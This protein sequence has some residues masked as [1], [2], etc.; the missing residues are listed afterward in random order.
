M[1]TEEVKIDYGMALL[2]PPKKL[3]I[4]GKKPAA[5]PAKEAAEA[6]APASSD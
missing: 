2:P 4:F 5:S 3:K 6:T 1:Q